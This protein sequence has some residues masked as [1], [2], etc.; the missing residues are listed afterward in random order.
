[1]GF[2]SDSSFYFSLSIQST[3]RSNEVS[4][5]RAYNGRLGVWQMTFSVRSQNPPRR[6]HAV[7]AGHLSLDG[8]IWIS[9]KARR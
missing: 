8:K 6:F 2:G 7:P 3:Q 5:I 9:R 1:M 4:G